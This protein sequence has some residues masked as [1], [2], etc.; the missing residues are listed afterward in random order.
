MPLWAW[1]R[2]ARLVTRPVN[3]STRIQRERP[4]IRLGARERESS[5]WCRYPL[6]QSDGRASP[7]PSVLDSIQNGPP[8]VA[9]N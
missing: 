9:L 7:D 2:T 5:P 8:D 6:D 4:D 3:S 1:G